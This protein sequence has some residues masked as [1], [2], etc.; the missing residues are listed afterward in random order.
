M[1]VITQPTNL[2]FVTWASR[3]RLDAPTYSIPIASDPSR[4]RE[5]A[6]QLINANSIPNVPL[7]HQLSYPNDENWKEWAMRF[8]QAMQS[9]PN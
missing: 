5:W 9:I 2:D 6:N 7:P 3:I 8:Y 4:W 1:P